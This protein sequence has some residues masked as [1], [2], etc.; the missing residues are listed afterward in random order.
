MSGACAELGAR[1]IPEA[2]R[3]RRRSTGRT[4]AAWPS[5]AK[6][7]PITRGLADFAFA[8]QG[9]GS[10]AIS[11]F[12]TVEQKR[13][14]LPQGR[15]RRSHRGLRDDRAGMRVGR[16]EHARRRRCA[17]AMNGCSSAKRRTSPTAGIADFYVTFA[18]T[19]EG[20]GARGPF[21]L[22][23]PGRSWSSVEERIDVIA[24]HP[25]ARLKY[26]NVAHPR[27]RDRRR[28]RRGLPDRHGNAQPVPRD[29]RRCGA[30]LCPARA[31]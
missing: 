8:M 14:W 9:L 13:E 27:R 10:G 5:R 31:G 21:R 26:D 15:E 22:H 11:L 6:R 30:R 24:P 16:R 18:R 23:R 3:R 12:G 1:G 2:L 19:G 7:L 17:T 29:G 4:C 28:T 25:L 20:E